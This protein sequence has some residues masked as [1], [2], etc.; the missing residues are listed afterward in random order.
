VE[1]EKDYINVFVLIDEFNWLPSESINKDK[2]GCIQIVSK[3]F[4]ISM[5]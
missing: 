1:E 4:N 3:T 2:L 5:T